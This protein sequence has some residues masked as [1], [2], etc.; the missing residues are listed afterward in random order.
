MSK[1]MNINVLTCIIC[2]IEHERGMIRMTEE[3]KRIEVN[4]VTYES[5]EVSTWGRVRS[6]NYKGTGKIEIMKQKEDKYGYLVVRL[7]KNGKRK[8]YFV[9]RL[10]A[11]MFIPNPYN[12]PTVNHINENKHDNRVENLEWAT[13]KEQINHGTRTERQAK[14]RRERS[15]TYKQGERKSKRVL[16]VETGIIYDSTMEVERVLGLSHGHIS[17]CC[18]KKY[19][20]KSCGGFHWEYVDD[21]DDTEESENLCFKPLTLVA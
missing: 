11:I 10:V 12:K 8:E 4:G 15:K 13:Q 1:Y 5:Y 20:F 7:Y 18:R 21:T 2:N 16:C 17:R 14:T 9:H 19:G 6:L 3:W